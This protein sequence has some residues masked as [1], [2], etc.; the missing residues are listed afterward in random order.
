[1]KNINKDLEEQINKN[2]NLIEKYLN[3]SFPLKKIYS[4]IKILAAKNEELIKE[5]NKLSKSQKE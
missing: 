3:S 4:R 1:M 5:L 2:R